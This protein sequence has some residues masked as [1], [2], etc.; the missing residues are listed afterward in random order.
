LA[1]TKFHAGRRTTRSY[2]PKLA[3]RLPQRVI[4]D[5]V[6]PAASPAMSAMPPKAEVNSEDYRSSHSNEAIQESAT[7]LITFAKTTPNDVFAAYNF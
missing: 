4:R 7:T 5:R 2:Y 6:E 3:A 1:D